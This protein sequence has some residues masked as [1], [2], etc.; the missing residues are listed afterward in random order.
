MFIRRYI[1][2]HHLST[3]P[4]TPLLPLLALRSGNKAHVRAHV[5]ATHVCSLMYVHAQQGRR[6]VQLFRP[7]SLT[8]VLLMYVHAHQGQRYAH[9]TSQS[10]PDLPIHTSSSIPTTIYPPYPHRNHTT[11]KSRL[12]WAG[13]FGPLLKFV[14][15]HNVNSAGQEPLVMMRL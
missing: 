13:G 4:L 15:T 1:S 9:A 5:R 3:I 6:Y 2:T 12:F 11:A 10:C 7:F 8:Y 14:A